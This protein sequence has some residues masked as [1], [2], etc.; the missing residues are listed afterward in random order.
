[1]S[2]FQGLVIRGLKKAAEKASASGRRQHEVWQ[3]LRP[4]LI[5]RHCSGMTEVKPCHEAHQNCASIGIIVS[6]CC[7]TGGY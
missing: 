3:G 7:R 4:A 6:V 2:Q 1:V 5:L